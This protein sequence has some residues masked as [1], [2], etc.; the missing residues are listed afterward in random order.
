MRKGICYIV[1][2][3]ESFGISFA[4]SPQDYV[5]AADGGYRYLQE[6]DIVPNAVIGDF[7]SLK[8]IPKHPNVIQLKAE[9]DQTDLYEAMRLGLSKGYKRFIIYGGTGGRLDHTIANIQLLCELANLGCSGILMGQKQIITVIKNDTLQLT[10]SGKISVFSL[11]SQSLGVTLKG[12]KYP[13]NNYTMTNRY[14]I[15]VSNEFTGAPASVS[16]K[17]GELLLIYDS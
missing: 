12:L 6:A 8:G 15:G 4:A 13:L 9:K 7:D 2:A 3:G 14:P 10:G 17:D 11:S 5:V 16:V 1:G